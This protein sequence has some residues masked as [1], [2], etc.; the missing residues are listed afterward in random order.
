M[1]WPLAPNLGR[2]VAD[3]GDPF[4][5]IW[6]LD[7]DLWAT[8]H[9]PFS[10]YHA[11]IFHPDRYALAFSENL[12]AIALM[13]AP[14]RLVG[15][16]PIA[17]YNLAML[18]GY[19][20]CGF[21]AYLLGRRLTGSFAAGVAAGVF[22]A[23]VP[24]RFT[25]AV[26]LQH[27]WGG[28]LP[29][30]LFTLLGYIDRPTA[31]RAALFAVVFVLN[32]LTNVHYFFF[33]SFAIAV[34][35]A[36][37]AWGG[38]REWKRLLIA[39][40]I[41]LA[42]LAPF[43]YPYYAVQKLYGMQRQRAEVL[44]HSAIP[45]DWLQPGPQNKLYAALVDMTVDP[46]RW[47]FP[48]FLSLSLGAVALLVARRERGKLALALLWVAIGFFGSLGLNGELHSFL[49]GGVPGFRA[50]RAPAR[51]AVIAYVGLAM[52]IAYTTAAL[53]RRNRWAALVV[54]LAFLV[55]LRA[56]PFRWQLAEPNAPAVYRWLKETPPAGAVLE[57][58]IND[59]RSEY[60]YMLRATEHHRPIVNG[61]SGFVPP[62]FGL[63]ATRWWQSP[64][65]DSL[66]DELRRAGV[67][68]VIV[69]ADMLGERWPDTEEWLRR[70]LARGRLTLVRR[71]DNGISG[72]WV[73]R[74]EPR[75]VHRAM[76]AQ[77]LRPMPNAITFGSLDFPPVDFVYRAEAIFSGWAFSPHGIRK[78]DLLFNNGRVRIPTELRAEPDLSAKFPWYPRVTRP[79]FVATINPRA[80]GLWPDTDVQPE[81][82]DGRG[83]TTRLDDRPFS[84]R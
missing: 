33:G 63:L 58:P 78:V 8:L 51:W 74:V 31:R 36:F 56:A 64:I 5:N 77:V 47:I 22:Y 67:S 28:W 68:T 52:L 50:I 49:F 2:A 71:F 19:A 26:H 75:D 15:V 4:I 73:F 48:G 30:L 55:E 21:G 34:T 32:G 46:E 12:Y 42:I 60:L 6:I 23:F 53:G 80:L 84:W 69:H 43:F 24:F 35:C 72:D 44:Q 16:P 62:T 79:R 65:A 59:V 20:L 83:V 11:R 82:T 27:V 40:A 41:G 9:Q 29:L 37:V 70:E 13:T 57:L 3:A 81:I 25:H 76:P 45:S 1:T 18:A 38:F 14:L 54:P 66:V 61:T 7:W 39:G 17:T 10:L